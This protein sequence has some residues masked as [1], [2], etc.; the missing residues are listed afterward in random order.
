MDVRYK[1]FFTPEFIKKCKIFDIEPK[2]V[3]FYSQQDEDK[4]IIQYLLKNKIN[5][6]TYLEIVLVMDYYIVILKHWKIIL[7]LQAF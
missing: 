7:I 1:Y 3:K 6:G 5:D 2:N 4:Y